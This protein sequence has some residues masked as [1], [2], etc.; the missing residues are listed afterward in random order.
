MREWLRSSEGWTG[1]AALGILGAAAATASIGDAVLFL[2][3]AALI[4]VSDLFEVKIGRA[5]V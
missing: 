3:F 4:A 2:A 1:I 5:H